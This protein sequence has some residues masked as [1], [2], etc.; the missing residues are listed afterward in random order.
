MNTDK[1][2]TI[3]SLLIFHYWKKQNRSIK[4]LYH[5]NKIILPRLN[6]IMILSYINY[7]IFSQKLKLLFQLISGQKW[8]LRK[9]PFINFQFLKLI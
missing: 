4:M 2:K 9:R 1:L 8:K 5:N 6:K 7:R 3:A